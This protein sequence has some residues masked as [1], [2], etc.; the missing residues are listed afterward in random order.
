[1]EVKGD[2]S[3]HIEDLRPVTDLSTNLGLGR[4][5][6]VLLRHPVCKEALMPDIAAPAVL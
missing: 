2:S 6:R 5:A 1:M 4:V 3:L